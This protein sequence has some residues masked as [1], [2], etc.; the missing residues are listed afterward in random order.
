MPEKCF[1]NEMVKLLMV[2][3]QQSNLRIGKNFSLMM[4]S[5]AIALQSRLIMQRFERG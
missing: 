1:V 2:G 4:E 5:A 3:F